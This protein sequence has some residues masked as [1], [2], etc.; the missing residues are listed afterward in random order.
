MIDVAAADPLV[1]V[2]AL[3]ERT[4]LGAG[5][6]GQLMPHAQGIEAAIERPLCLICAA[7]IVRAAV[8]VDVIVACLA[9]VGAFAG[10]PGK[11]TVVIDHHLA[12]RST[13]AARPV[14]AEAI[15]EAP[16]KV[17]RIDCHRVGP[18]L[19][20]QAVMRVDAVGQAVAAQ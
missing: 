17:Q 7:G 15:L 6:D 12:A 5:A 19:I 18:V 11:R 10:A 8:V 20:G 13:D 4:A 9:E 1:E 3:V 16:A 2:R 14:V